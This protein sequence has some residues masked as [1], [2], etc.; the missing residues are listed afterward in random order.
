MRSSNKI[1]SLYL[2]ILLS[3]SFSSCATVTP[4]KPVV[5]IPDAP[6]LSE[7]PTL[8]DIQADIIGG[9]VTLTLEQAQVLRQWIHNYI[10]CQESNRVLLQGYVEKLV[11]RLKAVS[12]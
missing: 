7:C 6:V 2:G 10:T 11:N 8:P 4:N 5:V 9:K 1:K 12:Q 3:L